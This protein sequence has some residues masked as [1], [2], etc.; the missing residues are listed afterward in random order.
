MHT[1]RH[2][3]LIA[4]LMLALVACSDN[5]G[6]TGDSAQTPEL[7]ASAPAQADEE[8]GD[9]PFLD[10]EGLKKFV[11]D[12][13]GKP[14]IVVIWTTWCPS[15]KEQMPELEALHASH[16]DKV[17]VIALSLDENKAALDKYLAD[18]APALPVYWGDET[19]ASEHGVEAIPT[20]L[21]FDK[22]GRK[23]FGQAGVFPSSM[24]GAMADKLANE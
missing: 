11:T 15:C 14:S 6:S 10:A 13:G 19:I 18:K 23:I 4:L 5:A 16:G 7:K 24:L 3:S 21:I 22:Q 2:I 17:N 8:P 1:L 9:V 20:L 12:N